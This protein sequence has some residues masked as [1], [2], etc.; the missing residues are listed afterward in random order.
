MS[1]PAGC[2]YC[3]ESMRLR[4]P[5]SMR[6]DRLVGKEHELLDQPVGH[7]PLGGDDRLDEPLVIQDELR[8][9]EVEVD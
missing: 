4:Q 8:F 1:L 2:A 5:G 6:G 7:V 9:L 3:L